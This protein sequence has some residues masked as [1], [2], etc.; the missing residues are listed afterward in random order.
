MKKIDYL[1]ILKVFIIIVA[2]LYSLLL[3]WGYFF[4]NQ[5]RVIEKKLITTNFEVIKHKSTNDL[6]S[7]TA[8]SVVKIK[9]DSYHQQLKYFEAHNNGIIS[10]NTQLSVDYQDMPYY[11]EIISGKYPK[12]LYLEM[13]KIG[14]HYYIFDDQVIVIYQPSDR[15]NLVIDLV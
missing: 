12:A 3:M 9:D 11:Q 5:H 4:P 8:Y 15:Y 6:G 14:I 7:D 13:D 2:V 1:K 10:R